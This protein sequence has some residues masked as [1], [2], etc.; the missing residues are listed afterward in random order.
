MSK[1]LRF[2]VSRDLRATAT[3]KAKRITGYCC[4]WNNPTNIGDFDEVI[5]PKPF[6]SLDTD[7][8]VMNFNHSDDLLLGRAGVNLKLEQDAVGLRFDCTLNDSTVAQDVYENIQS[9]ILS[10]CSFAFTVKPDGELWSAQP[11]G[12]MLRVLKN[13]QLWDAS[14]VT[15]P[16]YAGT[17]A[18]AAAHVVLWPLG[19][20]RKTTWLQALASRRITTASET[21]GTRIDLAT[22]RTI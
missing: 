8:V 9:G 5:S 13:M 19:S 1:E 7:S 14:V 21:A 18:Y 4:T 20:I 22:T 10:E 16:A 3:D 15:S 6:S 12:R 17:S 11:N 2:A